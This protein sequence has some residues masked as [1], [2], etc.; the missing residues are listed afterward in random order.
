MSTILEIDIKL[1][2]FKYDKV[3]NIE[4]IINELMPSVPK[5]LYNIRIIFGE[6]LCLRADVYGGNYVRICDNIAYLFSKYCTNYVSFYIS[7]YRNEK[8]DPGERG[9]IY[10]KSFHGT[11]VWTLRFSWNEA[12]ITSADVEL[13]KD[14]IENKLQYKNFNI[15]IDKETDDCVITFETNSI[16][17]DMFYLFFC[18]PL[19]LSPLMVFYKLVDHFH[20]TTY[21]YENLIAEDED[22]D[23]EDTRES[24]QKIVDEEDSIMDA[25]E[26]GDGDSFGFD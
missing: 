2:P 26:H 22:E 21:S 1:Q 4:K 19:S 16:R 25:L 23:E 14:N 3:L 10:T 7:I 13:L 17:Y 9:Y 15:D 18:K 12:L 8:D 11:N 5:D 24:P 20:E 6:H